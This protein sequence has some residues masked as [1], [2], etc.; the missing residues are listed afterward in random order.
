MP[1]SA[2]SVSLSERSARWSGWRRSRLDEVGAA[3]DD[4]GLRAAEQLVA[5]EA[6]EV[7]ARGERRGRRR[8]ALDVD[9]RA[10][11][12]IVDERQLVAARD[13]RELVESRLL[14]EADDAEVRLVH[15]QQQRGVRP[16]RPLVVG[17]PGP[18]RR[19]DLD[20]ARAR[21]SEHVR[22]AEAVADLDQLA[23]RDDDLATLGERGEREQHRGG[24]VVDDDR[25]LG[26]GQPPQQRREVVLARAARAGGE[27]VLE[28]RVAARVR[29]RARA[30]PR[31]A[32]RGR[33]SCA[34]ARRSR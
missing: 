8:L 29:E 30:R 23:A 32:A 9:E 25:R 21:A 7:R 5:G 31:R 18:V 11:A 20:E 15:A 19:P 22:D 1:S 33:G 26:S 2:A 16:D 27:V 14:G 3:G 17:G 10:R 12:E 34:R 28:V 24:V 4:P 6:D 13:R